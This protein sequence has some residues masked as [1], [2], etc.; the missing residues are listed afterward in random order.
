[1]CFRFFSENI[2]VFEPQG[3]LGKGYWP[4][5]DYDNSTY[6]IGDGAPE[7]VPMSTARGGSCGDRLDTSDEKFFQR[8]KGGG[9][10]QLKIGTNRGKV[11][12]SGFAEALDYATSEFK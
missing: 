11:N 7:Y 5:C 3:L 4:Y 9:E 10:M 1:M 2:V 12:L 6:K 8:M